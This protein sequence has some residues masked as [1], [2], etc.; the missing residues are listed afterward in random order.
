M[1]AKNV[2]GAMHCGG[3]VIPK[4]LARFI[5]ALAEVKIDILMEG[6]LQIVAICVVK[7][8][9]K[10]QGYPKFHH[11]LCIRWSSPSYQWVTIGYNPMNYRY[12]TYKP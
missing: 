8:S 9:H 7:Y 12:I 3:V 11:S 4:F 5:L 1:A 2:L 6:Q 10:M